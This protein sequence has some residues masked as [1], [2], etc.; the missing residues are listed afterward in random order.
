MPLSKLLLI[1]FL[2]GLEVI[3][4]SSLYTY[5]KVLERKCWYVCGPLNSERSTYLLCETEAMDIKEMNDF[6]CVPIAL[7]MN[8]NILNL[9]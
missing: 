8:T 2:E 5:L 6:G 1:G 7:S 3:F 4:V 9:M